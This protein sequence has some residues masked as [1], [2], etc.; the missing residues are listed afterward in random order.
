[1]SRLATGVEGFDGMVQGGLPVGSSVI[2]QGPPGQEKLR[3]ALTF[4]AEGLRSGASGLIVTASQSPDAVLAELRNLGV[5]L[6]QVAHENRLRIVD[7]YSWSEESVHDVEERGAI[8]RSSIDLTNLGVALSRAIT[9][10]TGDQPRRAVIELLSPATNVYELTQVYAFAQSAKRKFDRY[11]FTSLVLLEKEMHSAP[12]LTTLHQPFDGVIEI[13][14][15][16]S[17]D[18]IVRKVGVL[19][20]KD[21]SP[22]PT[23]RELDFSDK[24]MRVVREVTKPAGPLRSIPGTTLESQEERARRLQLIMQI[25][26]ERLKLNP[27]DADALFAMAAAQATLDDVRGGLQTLDRLAELIPDYP[28][29]WV[30][31]TKLHARLGEADRARQSRL[32]AQQSQAHELEKTDATVPCPMCEAPVGEDATS[33]TNCG[34][35]FA[36]SK[37]LEAELDQLGQAAIQEMVEEELGVESK[38]A[39]APAKPPVKPA[40]KSQSEVVPQLKPPVKPTAKKG[41]TNGLVL[42]RRG[43]RRTGMTNGLRGRTNGLRGRTNGLTNGLGRTNGLTQGVGRTNGLTNGVGRT[44]GLTNGLGHTNG[45]TNGLGRTNGLT[46]GLGRTNGVTN[47]L[48]RTNGL[49]NGLAGLRTT[50]FHSAGLRGM[51]RNAGWKLYLIPLVTVALLLMPLFFVPDYQGNVYPIQIDGQFGDWP[52]TAVLSQSVAGAVNPNVDLRGIAV[53]D[54]I[55]YLAFYAQVAG[56]AFS[57]GGTPAR[58][59]SIRWFI[60][61][62]RV[63]ATGYSVAGIGAD[64]LIE[65]SGIGGRVRSTRMSEWDVNRVASDWNGWIKATG[66]QAASLGAQLE[67]QVDWDLLVPSKVPVYVYAQFQSFDSSSDEADYAISSTGPNL[68]VEAFPVVS[69][70][71]SGPGQDLLRATFRCFAAECSYSSLQARF[72]GTAPVASVGTLRITDGISAIAQVSPVTRDVTLQFPSRTL[73]PGQSESLTVSADLVAWNGETLGVVIP[74]PASVGLTD[75]LA[76]VRMGPAPRA[77]GYLGFVPVGIR[78][79]GGFADW[80]QTLTDPADAGRNPDADLREYAYVVG[81]ATGSVYL[82]VSGRALNGTL[83]PQENDAVPET[84]GPGSADSDR[85][86]VPDASDPSPYDFNNDGVA[87]SASGN[88][89]DGD[90]L[91]DY[92]F[93]SDWYLNTTIPASFPPPYAGRPVSLFIGPTVRPVLLGEDVARVYLDADNSTS[94]G[95]RV[96]TIG[97]DYLIEVRGRDGMVTSQSLSAFMGTSQLTWDWSPIQTPSVAKDESRI[98]AGFST[99]GLGFANGSAAYVEVRDWTGIADG[100]ADAVFRVAS[101]A[102]SAPPLNALAFDDS[103]HT[104]DIPGN[105]RWFFT[106]GTTSG[107]SCTNNYAASTTA[108]SSATSTSISTNSNSVCWYTPTGQPASTFAGAWEVILDVSKVDAT[109]PFL[110]NAQG[111][112]NAWT[113]GTGCSAGS[114][115]QCVDEHPND[116]DTSY[117]Q[118]TGATQVKSSF[119]IPDWSSPPSPLSITSVG[120]SAWCK[121]PSNPAGNVETYIRNG[122]SNEAFGTST[123]CPTGSYTEV[124]TAYANYPWG[125]PR[126]WTATDVNNLEIGMRDGDTQ[127]RTVYVS[128]VRLAVSYAPVYSVEIFKCAQAAC[129]SG[130]AIYGPTNFASFG[131][132]VTITTSSLAA[133]SLNSNQRFRFKI[134]LVTGATE[135]G[136]ISISYNGA[137]GGSSD[138]RATIPIPEFEEVAIPLAVVLILVP[139][140]RY[141]RTRRRARRAACAA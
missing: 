52:T 139:A 39:P 99:A 54:N 107:T 9:S 127:A 96:N 10:L 32:R 128:E 74:G 121:S 51:M 103:V 44:N 82:R 112:N 88:D 83:V 38:S 22:D 98:E 137:S 63:A 34:V 5:N 49:T 94:T 42:E 91:V 13:E 81:N 31:K 28:G 70:I 47:G 64:R 100:G 119:A 27:R 120:I 141:W 114:E 134:T 37:D 93:G 6:D 15:T 124:A 33:C 102:V 76:T 113:I 117:L 106:N 71:L 110:P 118:S 14:R 133:Q 69:E 130:S 45:L 16:R 24:G 29:L 57:G 30:L 72:V 68:V 35:K 21:S 95:F 17:G 12:Q 3:F 53:V 87:D 135:G 84:P 46:N 101:Q 26:S 40:P 50:G 122:S 11:Q 129:T 138:S 8:V 132:D 4:L 73:Q 104:L 108:G 90:A 126:S 66:I 1:M 36:P 115:Y 79:D 20:L 41:L 111:S 23:F 123:N 136:S 125:T 80:N 18:R 25:A 78:L 131:S 67:L 89:Y 2:L 43:E 59:D 56:Q 61:T 19:H 65:V 7:W 55:Q 60:D 92:P 97:A 116:G 140:T 75:G 48:G 109:K 85:D 86:T 77:V 105:E 62:D 58:Y